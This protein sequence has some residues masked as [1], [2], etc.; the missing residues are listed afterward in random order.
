MEIRLDMNSI[1]NNEIA[2]VAIDLGNS[3]IKMYSRDVNYCFEL[4]SQ[5]WLDRTEQIVSILP[6]SARHIVI[7]SVNQPAYEKLMSLFNSQDYLITDVSTLF[8]HNKT[9]SFEKVQGMGT[10]RMLGLFGGLIYTEPPFIVIDCGTAVTV[11]FLSE[12]YYALGGAIFPGIGTQAKA[13]AHFTSLLPFVESKFSGDSLGK[14]TIEAM[15]S[16]I[17]NSVIGGIK[18]VIKN[19]TTDYFDKAVPPVILTGGNASKIK[20]YMVGYDLLYEPNLLQLGICK[21]YNE[22]F[23]L[24]S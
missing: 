14:S 17:F 19:V 24:I 9:I 21:L 5:E 3:R 13:L 1:S 4:K 2:P 11:N 23:S 16:G 6:E 22:T 18:E 20:N 8:K 12:D 15:Q 7:S 10:D